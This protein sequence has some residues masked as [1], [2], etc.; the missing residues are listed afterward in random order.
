[1]KN[2][3]EKKKPPDVSQKSDGREKRMK[4]KKIK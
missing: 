4:V 1:M 3:K 2:K